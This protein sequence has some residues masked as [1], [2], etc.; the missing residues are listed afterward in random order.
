MA[1]C[2]NFRQFRVVEDDLK[3]FCDVYI[4]LYHESDPN[5]EGRGL[6]AFILN[7]QLTQVIHE[8]PT[9]SRSDD[10]FVS[11]GIGIKGSS[12]NQ[13]NAA[14]NPIILSPAAADGNNLQYLERHPKL[15]GED[16]H[17]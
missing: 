16:H 8:M 12:H 7:E 4:M 11:V 14:M 17:T 5:L 9:V 10:I 3:L 13:I 15:L 1:A 6:I 2:C